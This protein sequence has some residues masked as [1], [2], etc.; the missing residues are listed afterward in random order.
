MSNGTTE[1]GIEP[2]ATTEAIVAQP[3][4]PAGPCRVLSL[5]GG[6]AKGFYTI[7]ILKEIEG[8]VGAPLCDKF[9]L[10]FGTSTGAIIAALLGLGYEVDKIHGLYKE[11]V[12]TIMRQR[13]RFARTAALKELTKKVFEDFDFHAFK[14]GVG[15]VA[16]HWEYERPMIFKTS[17]AQ[18][19]GQTG[20]FVPGFGCKIGEAVQ[21]S[22]SAFPFF[23][24]VNLKTSQGENVEV[25]DGG[26]CANNPTMYA[27]TDALR[28]LKQEPANVRV[29]S[30]GVGTYPEPKRAWHQ[31]VLRRHW[32][33]RLLQKTLDV[34]SG[35]MEQLRQLLFREVPTIRISE[36][37]AKPEMATDLLEYDLGKLDILYRQGRESFRRYE[38]QLR[39]FLL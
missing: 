35:S 26:F 18:A 32:L 27:I 22:C 39:E 21:A 6:G 12:P 17:V 2:R 1:V 4:A 3:A 34:N 5:D 7:G 38:A 37:F 25:A 23:D 8:I 15:I 16:T 24:R 9:Q 20:T 30:L 33:V 13:K 11:H 28:A 19:H 36:T 14:T 29:I 31:R 10:I